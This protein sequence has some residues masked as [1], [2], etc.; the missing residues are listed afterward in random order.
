MP[1]KENS[2]PKIQFQQHKAMKE[3]KYK[4]ND[5][6]YTA[7]YCINYEYNLSNIGLWSANKPKYFQFGSYSFRF[8]GQANTA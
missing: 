3:N 4:D 6:Q 2:T 8:D 7:N 1:P 5:R